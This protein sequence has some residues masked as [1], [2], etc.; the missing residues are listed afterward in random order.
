MLCPF[1]F[2][3]HLIVCY[4]IRFTPFYSCPIFTVYTTINLINVYHII[5]G[6]NLSGSFSSHKNVILWAP[7]ERMTFKHIETGKYRI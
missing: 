4:Q 3:T 1:N 5:V 2:T 7:L 6:N